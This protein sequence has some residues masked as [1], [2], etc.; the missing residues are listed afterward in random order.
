MNLISELQKENIECKHIDG[1]LIFKIE[2]KE[3]KIEKSKLEKMLLHNL[4]AQLKTLYE[5]SI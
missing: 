2:E 1:F 5:I 3:I 4:I